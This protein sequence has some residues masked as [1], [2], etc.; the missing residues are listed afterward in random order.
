M[1]KLDL[2]GQRFGRL[3]VIERLDSVN[4]KVQWLCKCD[5]GKYTVAKTN[6]LTSGKTKSCGCFRKEMGHSQHC[7]HGKRHTRLYNIWTCI[8]KRCCN[9][10]D[11]AFVNY[12]GRGIKICDEWLHD[13][14]SF[15][16][17]ALNNG[18]SDDLTIDRIDN[19]GNYEPQNCRWADR[20]TQSRNR[21]CCKN[22]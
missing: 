6:L 3:I 17:W 21:R 4:Y 10:N 18:Y 8:K 14:M 13:F 15:Y 22:V 7:K 5:C 19:D 11:A 16:E 12:G 20:L 2:L 9:L 1:S